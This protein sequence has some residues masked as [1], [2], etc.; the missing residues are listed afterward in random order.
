MSDFTCDAITMG[1]CVQNSLTY[2]K[3]KK[4]LHLLPPCVSSLSVVVG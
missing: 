2:V 4:G 3:I 1:S